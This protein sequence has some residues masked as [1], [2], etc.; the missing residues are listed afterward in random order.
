MV[1]CIY[2]C[3]DGSLVTNRIPHDEETSDYS[4]MFERS[5]LRGDVHNSVQ[6]DWREFRTQHLS[7]L[8]MSYAELM[9]GSY[10]YQYR[11]MDK[12]AAVWKRIGPSIIRVPLLLIIVFITVV[13][14]RY[15]PTLFI[16][17]VS[18]LIFMVSYLPG[19]S[20]KR[21]TSFGVL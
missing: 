14:R 16:A 8:G 4:C 10:F 13:F 12:I 20:E 3:C 18:G 17:P 11:I 5:Y 9:V 19:K 2:L 15:V 6:N 7:R 21:I 1:V